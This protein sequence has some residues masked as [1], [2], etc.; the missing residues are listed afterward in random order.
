MQDVNSKRL[1]NS[2]GYKNKEKEQKRKNVKSKENNCKKRKDSNDR[3]W[4]GKKKLRKDRW[5]KE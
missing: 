2:K 5:N 3:G 4:L 1:S